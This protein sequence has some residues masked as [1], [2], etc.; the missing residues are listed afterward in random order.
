VWVL[1]IYHVPISNIASKKHGGFAWAKYILCFLSLHA[2]RCAR[3]HDA[4]GGPGSR[5]QTMTGADNISWELTISPNTLSLSTLLDNNTT[6]TIFSFVS[7]S[8]VCCC[9]ASKLTRY[10]WS[11]EFPPHHLLSS[12][13]HRTSG[14][15]LIT[16]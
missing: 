13:I 16:S 6:T 12:V 9:V 5:R 4:L 11:V 8:K 2:P 1:C 3:S 10:C 15:S 14:N 7:L